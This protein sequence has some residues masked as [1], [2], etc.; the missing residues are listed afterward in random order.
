LMTK[1]D[2]IAD[3]QQCL[4]LNRPDVVRRTCWVSFFS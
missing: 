4:R 2:V 1:T 3:D